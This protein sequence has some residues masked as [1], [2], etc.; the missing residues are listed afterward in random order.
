[1][2]QLDEHGK[3]RYSTPEK[4]RCQFCNLMFEKLKKHQ[5]HCHSNPKNRIKGIVHNHKRSALLC[6]CN[7]PK[8]YH[9]P[10]MDAL[11]G[12]GGCTGPCNDSDCDC[13]RY[14]FDHK[15]FYV[16]VV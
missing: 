15:G 7:H 5:L 14:V 12:F 3:Y 13:D 1:M 11:T 9:R 6:K 16:V 8:S 4:Q 10:Q 2:D